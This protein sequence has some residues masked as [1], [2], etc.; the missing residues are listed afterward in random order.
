MKNVLLK[1]LFLISV[2]VIAVASSAQNLN[3][4]VFAEPDAETKAVIKQ[5]PEVLAEQLRSSVGKASVSSITV[6]YPFNKSVFP[7]EIVAP[8]FLWHDSQKQC[9]AWFVDITFSDSP[10][11]IYAFTNGKRSKPSID[12]DAISD[13]NK[14]Y[15]PGDYELSS[16]G[17]QPDEK[18]WS[19][20]KQ[21]SVEKSASITFFGFNSKSSSKVLSKGRISIITSSDPVG[22][23]VFYRDVPLMP[24][25]FEDGVIQPLSPD[26]MPL[27]SWRLR[28]ISKASAP[29]VLKDMPTCANCHSFSRDGKTLGMDMDGP[30]GDKGAYGIVEVEKDI[31]VT[32]A[33]IITWNAFKYKPKGHKTIGFFSQVS[34]DGRYV[35]S[36]VNESVFVVNYTDFR[37]LQS[38]YATKGIL[39]WYC[40]KTGTMEP[41][42]GADDPDYVQSN[43]CWSPD[44]KYL[45]FSRAKAKERY[46]SKETSEYAG[47]PRETFIQ[48][49][50]YKIPFNDG[51]GGI[52]VPVKG[53]SNN[54]MSNSFPKYSPDGKWLVFVQS[55]KGQLMRPDSRLYIVPADGGKAREMKC[56]LALMNSWH[57]W[58]PNNRWLVFSSK[59]LRPF[60]QMFLTHIDENGNDTPAILVP[61]STAAN[62]AVNIPEFLNNTAD[63]IIS[64]RAPSQEYERY[65]KQ[66]AELAKSGKYLEAIDKFNKT[67]EINPYDVE[68][69]YCLAVTQM[70]LSRTDSAIKNFKKT[71]QL[72]PEIAEAHCCLANLLVTKGKYQQAVPHYLESIK[73]KPELMQAYSGLEKILTKVPPKAETYEQLAIGYNH[74]KKLKKAE[75]NLRKALQIAHDSAQITRNL[76][77]VLFDQ[78]KI[79]EAAEYF[80]KVLRNRPD[81]GEVYDALIEILHKRP[82]NA[83]V[84]NELGIAYARQKQLEQAACLF[85]KASQISPDIPQYRKNFLK[86]AHKLLSSQKAFSNS[87]LNLVQQG[88]IELAISYFASSLN[89][90]TGAPQ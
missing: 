17:W 64:I 28:D 62:R 21:N 36:T 48:Y 52:A 18:T 56:N 78:G 67:I 35:V 29:V 68:A 37:F 6:D 41:L 74:L 15:K 8:T 5:K 7:P 4:N 73:I 59:G 54:S 42:P 12:P 79:D 49:N 38:F 86:T 84:Y 85:A 2:F 1:S 13:T 69:H 31:V 83:H 55:E 72:K 65:F 89:I 71:L 60:T 58:S 20:I 57:S 32:T 23:P 82:G 24:A 76:G 43:A 34:P 90:S 87:G 16:K 53:A 46:E 3:Q 22:A 80:V 30:H 50:L 10:Y 39:A 51:K 70:G 45:V 47:D 88:K 40:R 25:E 75:Q 77:Y 19:I 66:G 26:A 27:I 44:S 61:N 14:D 33:D 11:H 9:D 81:A 63:A